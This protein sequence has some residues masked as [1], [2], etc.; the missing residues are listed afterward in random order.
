MNLFCL[1]T[2][3]I[4]F[5]PITLNIGINCLIFYENTLVNI[6]LKQITKQYRCPI[7]STV[8][9]PKN[10]HLKIYEFMNFKFVFTHEKKMKTIFFISIREHVQWPSQLKIPLLYMYELEV[11]N[12]VLK[13]RVS[14]YVIPGIFVSPHSDT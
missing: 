8:G 12:M 5:V 11:K 1:G 10:I 6:D 3:E 4:V 7:L 13:I 14:N 9:D 2:I